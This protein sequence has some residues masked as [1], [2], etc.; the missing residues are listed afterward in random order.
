ME[1]SALPKMSRIRS[2]V[3]I[4]YWLVTD[5]QTDRQTY[6]DCPRATFI[7]PHIAQLNSVLSVAARSAQYS[8]TVLMDLPRDALLARYM[9]LSRVRLPVR[10]SQAGIVSKRL[11]EST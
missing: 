2:D 7:M 3:S 1:V 5:R 11:D 6:A 9:L 10:L 8:A 4:L